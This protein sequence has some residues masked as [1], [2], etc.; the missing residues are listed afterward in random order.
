MQLPTTAQI[1]SATRHV[2]SF[3]GGA[4]AMFGLSKAIDPVKLAEAIN[5]LGTL[6]QDLVTFIGLLTPLISGYIAWRSASLKSQMKAVE[7][8]PGVQQIVVSSQ[9]VADAAGPKVVTPADIKSG[10]T[11]PLTP[12]TYAPSSGNFSDSSR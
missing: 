2:A 10:N 8:A 12:T 6:G 11:V 9:A 5:A 1:A 4:V 7:A 3:A